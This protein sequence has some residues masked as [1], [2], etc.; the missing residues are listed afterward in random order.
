MTRPTVSFPNDDDTFTE[1]V[2]TYEVCGRCRGEGKHVNPAIDGNGITASEMDEL[3]DDFRDGYLGGVYDIRC[4]ECDGQ[5]V[6]AVVD[7]TK[8]SPELLAKYYE[9]LED[10]GQSRA[11]DAAERRAFGYY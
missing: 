10:E 4:Q 3:G 6:V 11:E 2:A 5:R 1:L 7:E 9:Y 8:N